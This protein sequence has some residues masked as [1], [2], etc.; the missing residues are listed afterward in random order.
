MCET[1]QTADAENLG[2][3]C[4]FSLFLIPVSNFLDNVCFCFVSAVYAAGGFL[5]S[6][7]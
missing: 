4:T 7:P 6:F 3:L 5:S 2:H 1:V